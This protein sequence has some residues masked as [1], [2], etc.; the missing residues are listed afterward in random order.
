MSNTDNIQ[1][2][3][4]SYVKESKIWSGDVEEPIFGDEDSIAS[5]VLKIMLQHPDH[6]NQVCDIK[7]NSEFSHNGYIFFSKICYQT[8][9]K[10][11]NFETATRTIQAF[12]HF[13]KLQMK[14]CEIIGVCAANSDYLAPI[15]FG[16]MTAGLIISTLDPSFEENDIKQMYSVTRPVIVF[17]DGDIFDTVQ[18]ALR[19]S[20]L[21]STKIFTMKKHIDGVP[22]LLEF[23]EDVC[24]IEDFRPPILEKGLNQV[25]FIVGTSG[26]TG[27]PKGVCI[28]HAVLL[29]T[30]KR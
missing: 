21:S 29:N 28:S 14:Q 10:F 9:K 6:I 16:A 4:T 2:R 27:P 24:N 12:K 26:T 15:V 7:L 3:K 22:N 8:D 11:T 1:L 20:D 5:V 18:T 25:A 17:C 13:E 23:F 19:D 30:L